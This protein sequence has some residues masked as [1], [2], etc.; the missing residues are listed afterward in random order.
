MSDSTLNVKKLFQWKYAINLVSRFENLNGVKHIFFS[1]ISEETIVWKLKVKGKEHEKRK[2]EEKYC[3]N[4]TTRRNGQMKR[5]RFCKWCSRLIKHMLVYGLLFA[6]FCTVD[7]IFS[8]LYCWAGRY[9]WLDIFHLLNWNQDRRRIVWLEFRLVVFL[10]FVSFY[11]CF[12]F[13]GERKE[14]WSM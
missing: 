14:F 2:Q 6:V 5:N 8:L 12:G 9:T 4:V 7:L 13:C 3:G 10:H 11:F 1:P